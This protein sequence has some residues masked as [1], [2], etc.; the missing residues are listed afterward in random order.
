MIRI[1]ALFL[2][3]ASAAF[4]Q[5]LSQSDIVAGQFRPGWQMPSGHHMAALDLRLAPQWK[6]YWRAPG[7]AGIPPVFDWTGSQNVRAVAFH[8]PAPDVFHANGLQ[9]IGYHDQLV[10][11]IEVTAIDP[12]RPV[13]LRARVDIG[14]CKDICMPATLDLDAELATPGRPDSA[15]RTA[16]QAQP[17]SARQAGVSAVSCR[18]EPIKDGLRLT[19]TL[20]M[21]AKSAQEIVVVEPGLP[22]VWV[23]EA[24]VSRTGNRLTAIAD[25]VPPS[26]QPFALD[27][28]NVTLTVLG[29][30]GL[31]TQ[32]NGCPAP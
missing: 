11:P 8:W 7:D 22:D 13:Y 5:D 18:I 16:L 1:T 31:A 21:P 28:R 2:S 27:R 29:G 12:A 30:A 15:I 6:T 25:M 20:D 19:A 3:L 10:L 24:E 4:G 14:V 26:G 23:S 32:I 9:S 17:I